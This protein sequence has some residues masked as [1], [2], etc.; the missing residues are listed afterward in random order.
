MKGSGEENLK[1]RNS[2]YREGQ[3]WRARKYIYIYIH[4]QTH[5]CIYILIEGAI[6]GLTRNLS[7]VKFPG[8]HKDDPS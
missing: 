7:V 1:E 5:I 3:K 2:Q 4:T 8:L 6:L